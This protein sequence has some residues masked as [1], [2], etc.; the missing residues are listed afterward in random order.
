MLDTEKPLIWIGSSYK[1][2]VI[3]PVEV[4]VDLDM[5]SLWLNRVFVI[6]RQ[7]FCRVLVDLG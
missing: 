4:N 7:R 1:D 3:L 2:L 5:H 6:R